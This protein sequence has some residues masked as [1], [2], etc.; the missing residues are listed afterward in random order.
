MDRQEV[1]KLRVEL[2]KVLK[3]FDSSYT[4]TIGS[5]CNYTS[6]DA[7][8]KLTITPEGTL[9]K[10]ERDL[11]YFADMYDVEPNKI[12]TMSD[13]QKYSLV[14]YNSKARK[15]P[16][17]IQKLSNGSRYVVDEYLARKYFGKLHTLN[18]EKIEA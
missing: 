1:K 14:G 15:R 5:N 16:F 7:T 3:L 17:I 12:G 4:V 8:F 10:E 18:E 13:G 6:E 11:A 2:E 9:S